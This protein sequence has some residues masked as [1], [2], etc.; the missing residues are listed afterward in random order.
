[1][2]IFSPKPTSTTP[3]KLTTLAVQTSS[4]GICLGMAWGTPRITGNLIWYGDF[5]AVAHKEEQGGK[6]GGASSTSYT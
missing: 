1:M 2:S 6:G 5:E 3:Q 4:Y